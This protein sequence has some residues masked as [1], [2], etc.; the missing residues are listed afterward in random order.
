MAAVMP[1]DDAP[2]DDGGAAPDDA[3]GGNDLSQ[4]YTI[5]LSCMPDGTYKL[6]GPEPLEE[7]ASEEQ[8][9][10]GSEM[11]QDFSSMGEALK[12]MLAMIKA[13]PMSASPQD[14]FNAGYGAG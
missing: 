13:N 11:G 12:A 1:V 3:A 7:E 2:V 10:P 8:G 5:E 14:S 4:G 6:S 9:E